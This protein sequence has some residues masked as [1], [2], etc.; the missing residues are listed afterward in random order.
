MLMLKNQELE[1]AVTD[2]VKSAHEFRD[3][4]LHKILNSNRS[5]KE[6]RSPEKQ[7]LGSSERPPLLIFEAFVA[8]SSSL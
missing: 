7:D 3:P 2:A 4:K 8:G 1:E 6:P 5:V